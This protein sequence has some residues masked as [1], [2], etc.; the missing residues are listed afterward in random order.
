[1]GSLFEESVKCDQV[2]D[3]DFS[4]YSQKIQDA[5]LGLDL[6]SKTTAICHSLLFKGTEYKRGSFVVIEESEIGIIGM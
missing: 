5:V 1:M 2:L 6:S 3:F 4:H